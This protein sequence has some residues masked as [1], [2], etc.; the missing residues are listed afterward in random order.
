[1]SCTS[2]LMA[3]APVA[4]FTYNFQNNSQCIPAA[5]S[6]TNTSTGI[7]LTYLWTFYGGANPTTSTNTNPYVTYSTCGNKT[8]TLKVTA[9]N[10]QTNIFSQTIFVACDPVAKFIASPT[11]GCPTLNVNYT[12]QSQAVSGTNAGNTYTWD[13]CDGIIS[14]LTNPSHPFSLPGCYCT[15]LVV[16]NQYGCIDDTV[17]NNAVC[18]TSPPVAQVT[19]FNA[20]SSCAAPLTVNFNGGNSTPLGQVTYLWTFTGGTPATSTSATPN[21]TYNTPGSYSVTLKVTDGNGCTNT[22]TL[23]NYVNVATASANFSIDDTT[24]CVNQPISFSPGSANTTLFNI[25][26]NTYTISSGTL[27]G[28]FTATFNQAGT[29]TICL[30]LTFNGGCTANKCRTIVVSNNPTANF[31][32]IG[33]NATCQPPLNV[34]ISPLPQAGNTYQWSFT[35][36]VPAT[37]SLQNPGVINYLSCGNFSVS[38]ITT[39]AFGCTATFSLTDTI[40]IDCPIAN[41]ETPIIFGSNCIP[42]TITFDATSS[43]GSP[44]QYLWN[45]N[46]SNTPNNWQTVNTPIT[47]HTFTTQGCYD[48]GL[49]IKNSQN[50]KDTIIKYQQVCVGQP[51]IPDFMVID[52]N[53][54][55]GEY[56]PFINNSFPAPTTPPDPGITYLWKFGDGNTS[57]LPN[58]IYPY[59]Q[60]TGFFDVTLIMC[61]YGCCDTL[62]KDEY[63]KVNP[64]KAKITTV[65]YCDNPYCVSFSGTQSIGVDNYNWTFPSGTPPTSNLDSLLV[66]F[67]AVNGVGYTITLIATN[68]NAGCSD[69]TTTFVALN[70]PIPG[71]DVSPQIGCTPHKVTF[72]NTGTGV[73]QTK[74]QIYAGPTATGAP[75]YT[76]IGAIGSLAP[77]PYTFTQPGIYSF[78]QVVY[79]NT[80]CRDSLIRNGYVQVYGLTVN[81]SQTDTDGCPPQLV[82]FTNLTSAN[83]YSTPVSYLWNF[84]DPTSPNNTAITPNSSHTYYNNGSYT[85][86]L[87]VTEDHGCKDTLTKVNLVDIFKP[88]SNFNANDTSICN[89]DNVCFFSL[90]TGNNISYLWDFGDPTSGANNTSTLFN[91][92]HVYSN[93]GNYS[94]QLIVTDTYGC[95]DTLKKINN[96][97]VGQLAASFTVSDS[98]FACPPQTVNFT[99]TTLGTDPSS[100]FQWT[101]GDNVNSIEEDPDHIYSEAGYFDVTFTVTNQYGCVKSIICDSC[102]YLAGAT[103]VVTA[104]ITQ[105]CSPLQVCFAATNSNSI[106]YI[107]ADGS[108]N[109]SGIDLTGSYCFTYTAPGNYAASVQLTDN[110]NCT[111]SYFIDSIIITG[112]TALYAY[113]PSNICGSGLV[114]FDNQST[115]NPNSIWA[116]DFDDP[117]SGTSNSSS[118]E[119]PTHTFSQ[120]GSYIV[121]L[122]SSSGGGCSSLFIDTIIVNPSPTVDFTNAST[123]LCENTLLNFTNVSTSISPITVY[124]W[125]FDFPSNTPSNLSSLPNPTHTYTAAG[126]YDIR[127]IVQSANGCTDTIIK[128]I[129]LN[130]N[131]TIS[132][133]TDIS[134]CLGEQ[135]N[136]IY[137]G[138]GTYLWLPNNGS[139]YDNTLSNPIAT[140]TVT[141]TYTLIYSDINGCSDADNIAVIVNPI[142]NANAGTDQTTF[143]GGTINLSGSGGITFNWYPVASF[144]NPTLQYPP[145]S[146]LVTTTYTLIVTD[147]NGCNDSDIVVIFATPC[148]TSL[149]L[150]DTVICLGESANLT[151]QAS[152]NNF[153]WTSFPLGFSSAF[154][155]VVVSPL[156]TTT[157]YF[158]VTDI[159]NGCVVKDSTIVTVSVPPQAGAGPDLAIC[160]GGNIQLQGSGGSTYS[161]LPT[162]SLSDPLIANPIATPTVSTTYTLSV[163]DGLCFSV[164]DQMIITVN[165]LPTINAGADASICKNDSIQ[166]NA[167]G[168]LTYVWSPTINLSSSIVS[169]PYSSAIVT[170]TYTVIGT[171]VNGCT[172]NDLLI[173][174]VNNLP[175]ANAGVDALICINDSIQLNGSGAISYSWTPN[176]TIPNISNPFV[177]PSLTTNYILT[178]TDANGCFDKDTVKITVNPLPNA[179]AGPDVAI[180]F[181]GSIGLNASG[182][183]QYLW[184]PNIDLTSDIINNPT[185]NPTI[186]STYNVLITDANGCKKSDNLIVT[187]NPLPIANAGNDTTV[188]LFDNAQLQASGGLVYQWS[189]AT[190]LSNSVISNPLANPTVFTTYTV[191]ITDGN[192]C[193]AQDDV[194]ITQYQLPTADAGVDVEICINDTIQLIGSGGI[195]YQ[196]SPSNFLNDD[197]LAN[198]FANPNVSTT[199]TLIV[200]DIN[201]CKDDDEVFIKVNPLPNANAGLDQIICSNTSALLKASGGITYLWSPP[202][203]ISDINN[204]TTIATP[205]TPQYFSVLVTDTNGCIKSDSLFVDMLFPFSIGS[206]NDTCVC[207]GENIVLAITDTMDLIHPHYYTWLPKFGI[208]ANDSTSALTI[209]PVTATTYTLVVSDG[210]CYA[211]TAIID[212]CVHPTPSIEAGDNQQIV[213]GG[214]AQ[215][216]A[217]GIGTFTWLPD[218]ALSCKNCN[219]PVA[220]PLQTTQYV[221][222]ISDMYGCTNTDSLTVFVICSDQV[223]Y[224]PNAFTPDDK[225]QLN[226]TFKLFGTGIKELTYLKIYNRWGE[227]IFETDDKDFEWDGTYKGKKQ[228]TGVYIYFLEAICTTGQVISKQGN[229]SLIR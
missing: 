133:G 60:D 209:S 175:T 203:F 89:G 190:N 82:N 183:V 68:T 132:L 1:M 66:C 228:D 162:G 211:D 74:Y 43:T 16:T 62:K 99:N 142:P 18:V 7:G 77:P 169:N 102:I 21:I 152:T 172:A 138:N 32:L 78:K 173:L 29:Y 25:I 229:L 134:I 225:D 144:T 98:V 36:G 88:T 123:G 52:T 80:Y 3:Q 71:F 201:T 35:G 166:F 140:P 221:V 207:F 202:T 189:P 90:S 50:C 63:I 187:V 200:T 113:S 12:N 28:P 55:F 171:D 131:P 61:N 127:L 182:G 37:S 215:L 174:T 111:Y 129:T 223:I 81:Y 219:N 38:L 186:T 26:P 206:A 167:N 6:L 192:G 4:N 194:I 139:L 104:D 75:L 196:W 160:Q 220:N 188:C 146:P 93:I 46:Y 67:P 94:V 155:S 226:P 97:N 5:V 179:N 101:L 103:A 45:W 44:N 56:V 8:I 53:V 13:F 86:S 150:D 76:Y 120:P 157:Y 20:P 40:N 27:S 195:S 114:T 70:N 125:N 145:V 100:T 48:I 11:S 117:A 121:S 119:N 128:T 14:S 143:P 141:T 79:S 95:K 184:T 208:V 51:T 177:K 214:L 198:P 148:P 54:C 170:T 65:R 109:S 108:G 193:T 105:G 23:N 180:C 87:I 147:N 92:C 112:D 199:F 159:T 31:G 126:D 106:N 41:F 83:A 168:G 22:I 158:N 17:V 64:P 213:T 58:P 163:G 69:T 227:K 212:V 222:T 116:W 72:T 135:A 204:P 153:N 137:A 10:G 15:K 33:N 85:V 59:Q 181:G 149:A 115:Y 24:A 136:L 151:G 165:P 96:I 161:W 205:P 47:T 178:V 107:W 156:V 19:T 57:T 84:G 176:V 197:T 110:S 39:N 218:S 2:I 34:S 73:Y 130:S 185:A 164:T 118:L 91:P 9:S 30:N 124:S 191:L 210:Q 217:D 122:T 42:A 216:Y 224:I 154:S 49:I